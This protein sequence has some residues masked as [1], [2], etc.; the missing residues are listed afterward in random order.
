MSKSIAIFNRTLRLLEEF[1]NSNKALNTDEISKLINQTQRS[2]QRTARL[3]HE[4]WWLE[5]KI[6][7]NCV[8]YK[9]SSKTHAL[10]RG[11]K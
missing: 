11:A 3:L 8:L 1:S 7:N 2:A 9:A 4:S 5:C 6:H 10:F